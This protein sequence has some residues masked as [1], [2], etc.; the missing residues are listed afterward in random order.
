MSIDILASQISIPW[1]LNPY[2]VE[3]VTRYASAITRFYEDYPE[4]DDVSIPY[5]IEQLRFGAKSPSQI[6][7]LLTRERVEGDNLFT[8][9]DPKP[10]SISAYRDFSTATRTAL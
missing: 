2:T 4:D 1:S 8:G 3:E 9:R 10:W 5:L 6:H 7:N